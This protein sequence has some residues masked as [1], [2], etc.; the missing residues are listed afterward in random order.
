MLCLGWGPELAELAAS[1]T[2]VKAGGP[3]PGAQEMASYHRVSMLV[4][5][6]WGQGS[7]PA[8]LRTQ[9][10]SFQRQQEKGDGPEG[11]QEGDRIRDTQAALW[12]VDWQAG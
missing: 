10:P 7:P 6:T 11:K 9:T 2:G 4:N 1:L 5:A 12:Q 8:V 3:R